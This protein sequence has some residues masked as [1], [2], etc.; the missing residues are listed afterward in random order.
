M[1]KE[2]SIVSFLKKNVKFEEYKINSKYDHMGALIV[3]SVL[4]AGLNYEIVVFPRIKRILSLFPDLITTEDF[5]HIIR[6]CDMF[7]LLKWNNPIKIDRIEML[8]H[9]LLDESVMSVEDLYAWIEKLENRD[10]LASLNGIGPKT[11]DYMSIL[12]GHN[13]IAIDRHLVTFLNNHGFEIKEYQQA[14]HI[15]EDISNSMDI[16]L[17]ILDQAIWNYMSNETNRNIF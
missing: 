16:P 13:N 9:F 2:E 17:A 11:I 15:Y 5:S 7:G 1:T 3:D 6:Q 4:Q 10:K 12:A 14:K 8:T